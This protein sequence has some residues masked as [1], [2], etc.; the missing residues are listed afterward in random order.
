[1]GGG[2]GAGAEFIGGGG[3]RGLHRNEGCTIKSN[4]GGNGVNGGAN[5]PPPPHNYATGCMQGRIFIGL[6]CAA[7]QGPQN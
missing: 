3:A 7:A 1:M 2:K 4:G 6:A 5:G